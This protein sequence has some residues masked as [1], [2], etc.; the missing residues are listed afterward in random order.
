[1]RFWNAAF[2]FRQNDRAV[3]RSAGVG[4]K[5][6]ENLTVSHDG[7]HL[8]WTSKSGLLQIWDANSGS[9]ISSIKTAAKFLNCVAFAPHNSQIVCAGVGLSLIHISEPTRPY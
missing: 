8:A 1:M 2:A 7:Q 4:R 3:L 5:T 6:F 9:E